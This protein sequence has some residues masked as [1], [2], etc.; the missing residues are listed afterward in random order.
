MQNVYFNEIEAAYTR[1]RVQ[2]A[3]AASGRAAQAVPPGTRRGR[4]FFPKMVLACRRAREV[5]QRQRPV[6]RTIPGGRELP[7]A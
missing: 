7:A 3:V 6:M 5:F 4:P 2:D 1:R